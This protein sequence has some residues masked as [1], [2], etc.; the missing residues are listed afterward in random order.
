M[1]CHSA[2]RQAPELGAGA[3][4][5]VPEPPQKQ[6]R[7]RVAE[8]SPYKGCMTFEFTVALS[9]FILAFIPLLCLLTCPE[10][11]VASS[12]ILGLA[13]SALYACPLR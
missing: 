11:R 5:Y 8:W 3:L 10:G 7:T 1:S 12:Q 2:P 4:F 13:V 9:A 6:P